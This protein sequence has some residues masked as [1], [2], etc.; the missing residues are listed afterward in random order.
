MGNRGILKKGIINQTFIPIEANG[1]NCKR[2]VTWA[3]IEIKNPTYVGKQIIQLKSLPKKFGDFASQ[4][5]LNLLN[6]E[7][8]IT[9]FDIP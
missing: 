5:N 7:P 4:Y 8:N 1:E 9:I 6:I 2:P 3:P